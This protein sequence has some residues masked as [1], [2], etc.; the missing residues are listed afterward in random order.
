M[1]LINKRLLRN[2]QMN[3]EK[4][5]L[6]IIF[7]QIAPLI[8]LSFFFSKKWPKHKVKKM[9]VH[10]NLMRFGNPSAK[11]KLNK[12][13]LIRPVDTFNF[14]WQFNAISTSSTSIASKCMQ[15]S[16]DQISHIVKNCADFD[17]TQPKV[18]KWI[19]IVTITNTTTVVVVRLKLGS[20]NQCRS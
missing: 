1:L 5:I 10:S 17:H 18:I 12:I 16:C 20:A 15:A 8:F 4:S 11:M 6:M 19:S 2:Q 3:C 14:R 9:L 13:S 7:C